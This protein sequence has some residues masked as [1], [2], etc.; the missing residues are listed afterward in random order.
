MWV[1]VNLFFL[2]GI[3][4]W[5]TR[6]IFFRHNLWPGGNNLYISVDL[7]NRKSMGFD[8]LSRT[9]TMPS[10]KSFPSGCYCLIV[11]THTPHRTHPHTSLTHFV[12]KWFNRGKSSW[13]KTDVAWFGTD[14]YGIVCGSV[15]EWLGRWT[16]DQEVAGSILA[17]PLSSATLGKL[18]TRM[19]LCHQTV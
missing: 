5:N 17:S 7:L 1:G 11:L 8:R 15:A 2:Q 10:F 3:I 19:S 4:F 14:Q 9:T 12:T 16:C 18:L 13:W 6:R